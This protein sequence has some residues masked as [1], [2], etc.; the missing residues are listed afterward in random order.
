MGIFDGSKKLQNSL[1]A[2]MLGQPSPAQTLPS[3]RPN[4]LL[5]APTNPFR[6]ATSNPVAPGQAP[7][8]AGQFTGTPSATKP[9]EFVDAHTAQ[10]SRPVDD[11]TRKGQAEMDR[12]KAEYEKELNSLENEVNSVRFDIETAPRRAQQLRVER[13]NVAGKQ[14]DA[15]AVVNSFMGRPPAYSMDPNSDFIKLEQAKAYLNGGY[16]QELAEVAAR[17]QQEQEKAA[18][19]VQRYTELSSSLPERRKQLETAYLGKQKT[20]SDAVQK[21]RAAIGR[22]YET[23]QKNS[24]AEDAYVKGQKKYETD[25]QAYDAYLAEK[26]KIDSQNAALRSDIQAGKYDVDPYDFLKKAN[27]VERRD[28]LKQLEAG[29]ARPTMRAPKEMALP[30][31]VAAPQEL[32][33]PE[34]AEF[35]K[36]EGVD[37]ELLDTLGY[38]APTPSESWKKP[39]VPAAAPPPAPEQTAPAAAPPAAPAPTQEQKP[40]A[41][42]TTQQT[43]AQAATT[44]TTQATSQTPIEQPKAE[45]TNPSTSIKPQ[46]E[47]TVSG[48]ASGSG[49]GA[50]PQ[51]PAATPDQLLNPKPFEEPEKKEDDGVFDV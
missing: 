47:G 29:K 22:D 39:A 48:Q 21:V 7:A 8:P 23:F 43:A 35:G 31:E 9:K 46:T 44:Q 51:T 4:V 40:P 50:T 30:K 37:Q 6:L 16:Q 15:Q 27:L 20:V 19:D 49:Q 41:P 2:S 26:G 18:R 5:D 33:A 42:P 3:N 28:M 25:K 10:Y 32:V 17:E 11:V 38:K 1:I 45:P 14:M 36:I 24:L 13:Q 34:Y 12:L